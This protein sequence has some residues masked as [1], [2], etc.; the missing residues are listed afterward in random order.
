MDGEG[1][2]RRVQHKDRA[3]VVQTDPRLQYPA[4]VATD[5][6]AFLATDHRRVRS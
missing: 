4:E 5:I 3:V 1:L 2:V 6:N